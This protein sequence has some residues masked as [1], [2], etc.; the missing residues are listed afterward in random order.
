MTRSLRALVL[1]VAMTL[2]LGPLTAADATTRNPP[3]LVAAY[4]FEEGS[5]TTIVDSSGHGNHGTTAGA[6]W[7]DGPFGKALRLGNH[8][9]QLAQVVVP[10]SPSM[11][12]TT[13]MTLETW[14]RP[15]TPADLYAFVRDEP[16]SSYFISVTSM[17]DPYMMPRTWAGLFDEYLGGP[18]APL[19]VWTHVALTYGDRLLRL[20]FN[21]QLVGEQATIADQITA[22]DAPLLLGT[23]F[24]PEQLTSPPW[25]L[26]EV[27]VYNQALTA[28]QVQADMRRA[29]SGAVFAGPPPTSPTLSGTGGQG[30]ATLSW[31]AAQDVLGALYQVHRSTTAG[32]TPSP[33]T[34]VTTVNALNHVDTEPAPGTTYYKVVAVDAVGHA[35]PS[36]TITVAVTPITS[37]LVAAYGMNQTSGT[38]VTDASGK[39]HHGTAVVP[40]T[41][42]PGKYG[43]ALSSPANSSNYIRVPDHADLDLTTAV[44]LEYWSKLPP[45]WART[46]V[47]K[48]STNTQ[49]CCY[50]LGW[51][52]LSSGASASSRVDIHP[53]W[54]VSVQL[55]NRDAR[56]PADQWHHVAHT[57]D[58][59][60]AR[61]YVD[62][63][64]VDRFDDY[65][66]WTRIEVST[67]PLEM[68]TEQGGLLDEVRVYNIALSQAQI[69][70]NMTVP[71]G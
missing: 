42:A 33:A 21:G 46:W 48:S 31:T 8:S 12:L 59:G 1:P 2:A 70:H 41:S 58:R 23:L 14:I 65:S 64:L 32:F 53:E 30:R 37:A 61:L 20:Y 9:P 40:I 49:K 25:L 19:N 62:G 11:R 56:V 69:R 67:A 28:E 24:D 71:V 51:S 45:G 10:H 4:G 22:A 26:D 3:G 36:N 60:V 29:V 52:Q 15:T 34:L 7:V 27:R 63:N 54:N 13:G 44:T 5:G 6:Q 68:Y 38:T 35:T 16:S 47:N 57:F 43:N 17:D 39:S 66:P 18:H 55:D 50:R